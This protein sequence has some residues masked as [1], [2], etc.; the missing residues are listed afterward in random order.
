MQIYEGKFNCVCI[1]KGNAGVHGDFQ[2]FID[3]I[4]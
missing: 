1:S 4:G 2:A 3:I